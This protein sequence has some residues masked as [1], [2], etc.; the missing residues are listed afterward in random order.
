MQ[1]SLYTEVCTLWNPEPLWWMLSMELLMY[2]FYAIL[3]TIFRNQLYVQ[4][5]LRNVVFRQPVAA[6]T[7]ARRFRELNSL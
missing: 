7:T 3:T 6:D 1:W 2:Q 5:K 4:H